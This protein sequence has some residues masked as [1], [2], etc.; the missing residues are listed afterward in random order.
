MINYILQNSC[1]CCQKKECHRSMP[2]TPLLICHSS[3]SGIL[4]VLPY[5]P[6]QLSSHPVHTNVGNVNCMV[7]FASSTHF[8]SVDRSE[9][10]GG[11]YK[12]Q[13][14]GRNYHKPFLKYTYTF[15]HWPQ[16]SYSNDNLH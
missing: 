13:Q 9:G 14:K 12:S 2:S 3:P 16:C 15:F 1:Y 8:L 4:Y 10:D 11:E 5:I 7:N 6:L